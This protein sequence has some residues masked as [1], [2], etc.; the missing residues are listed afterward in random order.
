MDAVFL[1]VL[2]TDKEARAFYDKMQYVEQ[3]STDDEVQY[4]G[5]EVPT[6]RFAIMAK[7]FAPPPAVAAA[8]VLLRDM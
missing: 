6:R 2:G 8:P 3:Y 4:K 1:T 7:K 5:D